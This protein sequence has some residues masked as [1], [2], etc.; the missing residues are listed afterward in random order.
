MVIKGLFLEGDWK[1][2][3]GYKPTKWEEENPQAPNANKAICNPRISFKTDLPDPKI[4]GDHEV[5]FKIH[6]CGICGSD[7][8]MVGTDDKGYIILNYNVKIPFIPGHEFS[9]V[10]VVE[11]VGKSVTRVKPSDL[12]SVEEINWCGRC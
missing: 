7:V 8:H 5:L 10:V 4:S 9:G 2:R 1:P 6:L 3:L 11:E 12:I